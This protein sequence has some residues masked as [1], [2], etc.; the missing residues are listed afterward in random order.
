M[1]YRRQV[2]SY[3]PT[4]EMIVTTYFPGDTT[5]ERHTAPKATER[6]I[7][8]PE[9]GKMF[10]DEQALWQHTRMKHDKVD[11]R[12]RMKAFNLSLSYDRDD[13]T[14]HVA[15]NGRR[16][17]YSGVSPFWAGRIVRQA[18]LN[19]GRACALLRQFNYRSI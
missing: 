15:I 14:M 12:R 7:P 17:V 18:K 2:K 3:H 9:C 4:R 11:I 1:R 6:P 10:P 19:K 5:P 13:W 16:Y 8:C